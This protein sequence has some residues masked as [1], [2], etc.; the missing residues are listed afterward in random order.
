[1][2]NDTKIFQTLSSTRPIYVQ[3]EV[4]LSLNRELTTTTKYNF[5][6]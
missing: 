4:S 3:F 6:H 5:I 2:H 1:M